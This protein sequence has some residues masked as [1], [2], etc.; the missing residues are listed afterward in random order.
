MIAARQAALR[1]R[2][3]AA[4]R[5]A[6]GSEQVSDFYEEHPL[7]IGAVAFAAGAA[8]AGALPRTRM[9]DEYMGAT[10]DDLFAEAETIYRTEMAKAREVVDAG[11][12][13][14]KNI[15]EETR[16]DA[17]NAAPGSKSAVEAAA[18]KARDSAQR[19]ASAAK[20]KAE[21]KHLGSGDKKA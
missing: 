9:E 13:E 5:L 8:I 6:K 18:D 10:R 4:R 19:V 15:A 3:D 7:V 20:D 17:D 12:Q 21:E 2:D 1:A 11:L 14:A 16:A